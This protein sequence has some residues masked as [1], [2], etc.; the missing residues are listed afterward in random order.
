MEN[1]EKI[2]NISQNDN[3]KNTENQDD[4][5]LKQENRII[6]NYNNKKN[7]IKNSFNIIYE[8]YYQ[9]QEFYEYFINLIKDYRESKLKNIE[10][11][12]NILN[13]YFPDN[14]NNK[15]YNNQI[16][17]IIKEFKQIIKMQIKCEKDKINQLDLDFGKN[18][19]E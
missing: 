17:T 16:K 15:A 10:S 14:N 1:E 5:Y 2:N 18:I 3:K 13:K 7:R 6:N 19:E 4:L 8:R 9:S 12:S 11:L